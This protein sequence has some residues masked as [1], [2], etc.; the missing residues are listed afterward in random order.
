[1]KNIAIVALTGVFVASIASAQVTADDLNARQLQQLRV[2]SF[3]APAVTVTAPAPARVATPTP[4][5]STGFYVGGS[6][7][8]G[9]AHLDNRAQWSNTLYAGYEL[10]RFLALEASV[11]YMYRNSSHTAGQMAFGN[12]LLGVP[13]GRLT[14]YVLAGAGMGFNGAGDRNKDPQSLWNV[15]GGLILNINR[16]WQLDGRYRYIDSWQGT[17][18]AEQGFSL[19]VNYRF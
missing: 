9:G 12:A 10:N 11:D 16:S 18:A 5:V 17:R 15:G 13:V 4:H 1:M 8:W 19:G 3:T 14:P 2:N 6:T 7:G